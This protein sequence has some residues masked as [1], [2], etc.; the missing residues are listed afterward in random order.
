MPSITILFD[1][2]FGTLLG[3]SAEPSS[4][5]FHA[6]LDQFFTTN[7]TREERISVLEYVETVSELAKKGVDEA[8]WPDN[9]VVILKLLPEVIEGYIKILCG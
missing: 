4:T 5:K 9:D 6:D 3:W 8:E 7:L 2:L 1:C